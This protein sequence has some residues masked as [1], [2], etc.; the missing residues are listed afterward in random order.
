VF[1]GYIDEHLLAVVT[2]AK[3]R[4]SWKKISERPEFA[5][6]TAS[7]VKQRWQFLVYPARN[8]DGKRIR[9]HF[10]IGNGED[11][12]VDIDAFDGVGP[13]EVPGRW[14]GRSRARRG[15]R[16]SLLTTARRRERLGTNRAAAMGNGVLSRDRHSRASRVC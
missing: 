6:Y 10:P 4:T 3:C 12:E 2:G 7:I 11:G 5:D 16:S 14:R 9:A 15:R 1:T 13:E 8:E